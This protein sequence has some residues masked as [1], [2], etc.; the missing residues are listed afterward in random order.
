MSKLL[1]EIDKTT[2]SL[3]MTDHTTSEAGGF[4]GTASRLMGGGTTSKALSTIN[5]EFWI[6][7]KIKHTTEVPTH[8]L[9][10]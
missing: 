1:Q 10:V 3:Y 9:E 2:N 7:T 6:Q 8:N 4:E 5:I